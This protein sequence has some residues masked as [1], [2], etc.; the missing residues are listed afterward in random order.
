[1]YKLTVRNF[2]MTEKGEKTCLYTMKND[3]GLEVSVSDFG[4]TLV[5]VCVPGKDGTLVDVTLG[6]DDAAAYEKGGEAFG[7]TV[8]R[9]ANR[10][11]DA[12][13]E[14]NGTVDW[15]STRRGCGKS[16]KTETIM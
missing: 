16:W 3:S 1:M 2:G 10:I 9:S 11:K 14:I 6:Y 12:K 8:G 5:S 4:A 7:A 15:I 13:I